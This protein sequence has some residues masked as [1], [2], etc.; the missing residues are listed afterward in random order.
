[1]VGTA[2]LTSDYVNKPQEWFASNQPYWKD[3]TQAY[4]KITFSTAPTPANAQALTIFGTDLA[5]FQA[6][7]SSDAFLSKLAGDLKE[8]IKGVK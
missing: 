3:A 5:Q 1:V 7:Q 2:A 6:G 8:Q 4:S